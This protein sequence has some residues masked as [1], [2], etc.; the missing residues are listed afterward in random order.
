MIESEVIDARVGEPHVTPEQ[1]ADVNIGTYGPEDYVLSTGN[2]LKA[3]LVT[4]NSVRVFDGV[5][6]YGGIRDAIPVN[7]YYDVAIANGAQGKNRNDIIVRRYTKEE[8]SSGKASATFAVVKGTAVSGKASD[9]TIAKT[10]LRAG[11]LTH[12]MPLHRVRLE[13]LNI[14]AVDPLYNVLY[15]AAEL[16]EMYSELNRNSYKLISSNTSEYRYKIGGSTYVVG[17][18]VIQAGTDYVLLFTNDQLRSIF[19]NGF[20]SARF[21][22]TTVNGDSATAPVHFYAP[23]V[24]SDGS[25]YQYFYPS[26]TGAVRINYRMEYRPA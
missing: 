2:K 6:I 26:R 3:E 18:K 15:N 4:S 25:V 21:S 10:N 13:G 23:E 16:Q 9:P 1:I 11:A 24:W 22:I 20:N 14:V 5:M 8:G 17:S 12:D 19:G 7:K